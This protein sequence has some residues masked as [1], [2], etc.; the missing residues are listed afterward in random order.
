MQNNVQRR[1][2]DD[3]R[4]QWMMMMMYD[5]MRQYTVKNHDISKQAM[6]NDGNDDK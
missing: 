3:T 5:D 2:D 6:H 4:R 1:C